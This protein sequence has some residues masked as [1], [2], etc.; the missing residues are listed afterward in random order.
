MFNHL[1]V[2]FVTFLK[3]QAILTIFKQKNES[4]NGELQRCSNHMIINLNPNYS[5]KTPLSG[6]QAVRKSSEN[7]NLILSIQLTITNQ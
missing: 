4:S 6:T 2:I 1:L 5:Y 7:C 3:S